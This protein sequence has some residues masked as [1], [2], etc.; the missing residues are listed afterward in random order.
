MVSEYTDF[1]IPLSDDFIV[2]TN[3]DVGAISRTDGGKLF[4][5]FDLFI[6]EQIWM[7]PIFIQ[8][9]NAYTYVATP[10]DYNLKRRLSW[11]K[12]N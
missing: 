1:N 10:L 8:K 11:F 9:T 4:S 6:L 7:N 2:P 12:K 5:P 3:N